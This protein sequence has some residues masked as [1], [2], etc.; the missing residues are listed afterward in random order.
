[1]SYNKKCRWF[2]ME[3]V[4]NPGA[5]PSCNRDAV[6][7]VFDCSTCEENPNNAKRTNADRIRA[8]SDEELA[9]IYAVCCPN[10][11]RLNCGKY[12]LHGGR[13]CFSCWLDWLKSP[14]EDGGD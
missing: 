7:E 1:M 11:D 9:A 10:G 13:D 4:G 8:M 3:Y 6:L 2:S 5:V 12:Y 14:V